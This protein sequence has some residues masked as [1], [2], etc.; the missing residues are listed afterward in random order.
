V[1]PWNQPDWP[2]QPLKGGGAGGVALSQYQWSTTGCAL[3]P[4]WACMGEGIISLPPQSLL[5]RIPQTAVRPSVLFA[6]IAG[7][8]S[9]AQHVRPLHKDWYFL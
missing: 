1:T 4:E 6:W 7:A 3:G 2:L 5:S 8:R 9:N